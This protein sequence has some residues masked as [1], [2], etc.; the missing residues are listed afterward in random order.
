ML[1]KKIS[2]LL[3]LIPLAFLFAADPSS[4]LAND[5]DEENFKWYE[6]KAKQF[7]KSY[8]FYAFKTDA[9]R[10]NRARQIL[11]RNGWG[12]GPNETLVEYF[13]FEGGEK[14]VLFDEE[15]KPK[16]KKEGYKYALYITKKTDKYFTTIYLFTFYY[17]PDTDVLWVCKSMK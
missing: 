15:L 12:M 17:D 14:T 6:F 7:G 9:Q 5:A 4:K 11:N 1:K 3:F 8:K 16:M 13:N 2:V 10:D